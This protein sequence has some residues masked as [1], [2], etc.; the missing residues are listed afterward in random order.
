MK[1]F[2]RDAGLDPVAKNKEALT[3][4]NMADAGLEPAKRSE[5]QKGSRRVRHR[6]NG[7]VGSIQH[8]GKRS[9]VVRFDDESVYVCEEKDLESAI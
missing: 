5:L 3:K 8:Q 9:L 6:R 1:D 7:K 4:V 2:M